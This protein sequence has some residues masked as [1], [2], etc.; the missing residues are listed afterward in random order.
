MSLPCCNKSAVCEVV[1]PSYSKCVEQPTCALQDAPCNGTGHEH[2][3][4][5]TPCCDNATTC[6]PWG[7]EWSVCRGS[8][9]ETCSDH[10]EQCAGKG[11]SAM[12]PKPCCDPKEA[13]TKVRRLAS[14]RA[15]VP[16][17]HLQATGRAD[18]S[19]C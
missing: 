17:R 9:H 19:A 7:D 18:Y 5:L 16:A 8:G 14:G 12:Q 10:D 2:I 6:V 15:R 13:C 1:E 3:M 11:D 4:R